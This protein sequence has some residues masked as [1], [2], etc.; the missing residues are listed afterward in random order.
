MFKV[1]HELTCS[2]L[3]NSASKILLNHTRL[4]DGSVQFRE[5]VDAYYKCM[6]GNIGAKLEMDS[7]LL[8]TGQS[9]RSI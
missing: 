2:C 9:G 8:K 5:L 3:F 7:N 1:A 4:V 6:H